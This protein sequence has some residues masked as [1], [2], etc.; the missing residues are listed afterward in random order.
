MSEEN[1]QQD[2]AT[3]DAPEEPTADATIEDAAGSGEDDAVAGTVD[4]LAEEHLTSRSTPSPQPEGVQGDPIGDAEQHLASLD[5]E[6]ERRKAADLM[7][8]L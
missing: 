4:N 5:M 7:K 8:K 3:P 6:A 1:V 2:E